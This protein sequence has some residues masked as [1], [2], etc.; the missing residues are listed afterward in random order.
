MADCLRIIRWFSVG[1][2]IVFFDNNHVS[3]TLLQTLGFVNIM[4]QFCTPYF[5]L[6]YGSCLY[7][8]ILFMIFL[9]EDSN[10]LVNLSVNANCITL[11][12]SE[13]SS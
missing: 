1:E 12:S 4:P 2:I 8:L 11:F 13:R 9:K 5:F 10:P 3:G 6:A 7:L